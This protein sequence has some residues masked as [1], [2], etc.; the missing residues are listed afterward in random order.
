MSRN[1]IP[2]AGKSGTVRTSA[3]ISPGVTGGAPRPGGAAAS[4]FALRLDRCPD[5]ALGQIGEN[6]REKDEE[7][8]SAKTDCLLILLRSSASSKASE[9]VSQAI[10]EDMLGPMSRTLTGEHA[11]IRA[12]LALAVLM[13]SGILRSA[14]GMGP[15]CEP[16]AAEL[17]KRLTAL[18]AVALADEA[19]AG[20]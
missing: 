6:R 18:F 11:E 5:L 9:I 14:M 8:R 2:G 7:Q 19:V 15:L 1:R 4:V 13:G 20:N 3:L 17:R 16:A 12:G 10:S